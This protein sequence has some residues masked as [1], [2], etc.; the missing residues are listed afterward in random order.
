MPSL[1]RPAIRPLWRGRRD[2]GEA[3]DSS[4]SEICREFSGREGSSFELRRRFALPRLAA[5]SKPRRR[6]C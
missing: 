6:G 3:W 1:F 4:I 2:A 5:G